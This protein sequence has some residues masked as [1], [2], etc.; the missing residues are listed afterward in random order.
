MKSE[1]SG[2]IT[3][4]RLN[5]ILEDRRAQALLCAGMGAVSRRVQ[6]VLLCEDQQQEVFA[7]R[8]LNATPSLGID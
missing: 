3:T 8:F 6:L 7:R 2:S 1:S 4:R 5:E